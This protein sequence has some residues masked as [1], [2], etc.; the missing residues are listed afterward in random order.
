M[1]QKLKKHIQGSFKSKSQIHPQKVGILI[2]NT[3]LNFP[4]SKILTFKRPCLFL[5]SQR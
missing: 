4:K 3:A 5:E 1:F 2:L